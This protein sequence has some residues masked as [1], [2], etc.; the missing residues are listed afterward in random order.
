MITAE[1]TYSGPQ[2]DVA[3]IL[4]LM[5]E[6]DALTRAGD[7]AALL[8]RVTEDCVFLGGADH[9]WRFARDATKKLRRGRRKCEP[10]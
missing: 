6:W 5:E 8:E 4:A 3:A 1:P 2:E 7:H 9:I 10:S